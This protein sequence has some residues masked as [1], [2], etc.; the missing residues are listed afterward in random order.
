METYTLKAFEI[1]KTT[2][3]AFLFRS[4]DGLCWIPKS[5]VESVDII[6]KKKRPVRVLVHN[7]F[8]ISYRTNV[9]RLF[10]LSLTQ[11]IKAA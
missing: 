8:K 1:V 4:A 11:Q 7:S 3:K 9:N 6:K 2:A 10:L 5:C